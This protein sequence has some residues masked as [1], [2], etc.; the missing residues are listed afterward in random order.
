MKFN[1]SKA[2]KAIEAFSKGRSEILEQVTASGKSM[3]DVIIN[4]VNAMNETYKNACKDITAASKVDDVDMLLI[5][6][7]SGMQSNLL[8]EV[9]FETSVGYL[10]QSIFAIKLNYATSDEPFELNDT[11]IAFARKL[12]ISFMASQ[13]FR[14][15][16]EF[17]EFRRIAEAQERAEIKQ[18]TRRNCGNGGN[19]SE[20]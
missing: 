11:D 12:F 7:D 15:K 6:H 13:S 19:P 10:V 18:N 1:S 4:V 20:N 5:D 14:L 8:T 2:H 3:R 9:M 16:P 17:D